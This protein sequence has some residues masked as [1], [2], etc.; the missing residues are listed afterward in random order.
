MISSWA[1]RIYFEIGDPKCNQTKCYQ[2]I[3]DFSCKSRQRIYSL[4]YFHT[5]CILSSRHSSNSRSSE[6]VSCYN[7]NC[8][9]L[10]S[11]NW[12]WVVFNIIPTPATELFLRETWKMIY[13]LWGT[14]C[15]LG[16]AKK[17]LMSP[18]CVK[19][20][21]SAALLSWLHSLTQNLSRRIFW[22]RV[23]QMTRVCKTAM[24]RE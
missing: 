18:A 17:L 7:R 3:F 23:W 12:L 20:F 11:N 9:K 22:M 2:I 19:I 10:F 13:L 8:A 4:E 24:S 1:L 21:S 14:F 5:W 16:D 6:K 15:I